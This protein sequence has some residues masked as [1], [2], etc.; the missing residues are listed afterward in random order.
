MLKIYLHTTN[1]KKWISNVIN[2][3]F[4]KMC[5]ITYEFSDYES[6]DVCILLDY[7][8]GGNLSFI[9][10]NIKTKKKYIYLSFEN[11]FHFPR[12]RNRISFIKKM[13]QYSNFYTIGIV[14]LLDSD[15]SFCI[16]PYYYRYDYSNIKLDN[17]DER[18]NNKICHMYHVSYKHRNNIIEHYESKNI[19]LKC[20]ISEET[21]ICMYGKFLFN[22]A[23]ENSICK[24]K[25]YITEKLW[26]PILA[27]CIPIYYG[28][29]IGKYTVFNTNRI[30]NISN[31]NELPSINWDKNYLFDMFNLPIFNDNH[32]EIMEEQAYN[33][34]KIFL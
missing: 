13:N 32:K 28:G 33:F 5:N 14:K 20:E 22:V 6:S 34:K 17:F 30:I 26:D 7:G 19:K 11:I 21:K 16:S 3:Y 4:Y 24:N 18:Y 10:N 27:G 1:K 29:D 15:N 12:Y 8:Y 25:S 9:L 23:C 2:D 31:L